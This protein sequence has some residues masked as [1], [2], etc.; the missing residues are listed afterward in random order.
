V[1]FDHGKV[2]RKA[3]LHLTVDEW[4]RSQA[5]DLLNSGFEGLSEIPAMGGGHPLVTLAA[6]GDHNAKPG[7]GKVKAI[8]PL[9]GRG[10][11]GEDFF[12]SRDGDLWVVV[13][14]DEPAGVL[15]HQHVVM[16]EIGDVQQGFAF[17]RDSENRMAVGVAWG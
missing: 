12:P 3:P 14:V 1:I 17:R 6:I 15:K 10:D 2:P 16:R 9:L 13:E 8:D 4:E 11:F 5:L 7:P